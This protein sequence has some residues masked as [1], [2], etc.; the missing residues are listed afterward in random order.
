MVIHITKLK[1]GYSM[2]VEWEDKHQEFGSFEELVEALREKFTE[3]S[4]SE[5]DVLEGL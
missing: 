2:R 5:Y 4:D 1:K 3:K